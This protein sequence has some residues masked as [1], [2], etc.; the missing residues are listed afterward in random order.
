MSQF[1]L[2]PTTLFGWLFLRF[3]VTLTIQDKIFIEQTIGCNLNITNMMQQGWYTVYLNETQ[4][5]TA[6]K[7]KQIQIYEIPSFKSETRESLEY[8]DYM[9]EVSPDWRMFQTNQSEIYPFY[10][11]HYIISNISSHEIQNDKRILNY[12]KNPRKILNNRYTGGLLQDGV[13]TMTAQNDQ[14]ISHRTLLQHNI[15][16]KGRIITALDTGV[17]LTH[18]FFRDPQQSATSVVDKFNMDHRKIVKLEKVSDIY[19]AAQGHG[20]HVMGT[21]AGESIDPKAGIAAYNGIAPKAKLYV[22]D[23]GNSDSRVDLSGNPDIDKITSNMENIKSRVQSNS[24]TFDNSALDATDTYDT[25]TF[26]S[27]EIL[28]VFANGNTPGRNHILAPANCKN[29]LSVA[30][31]AK[32]E[33]SS[34]FKDGGYTIYLTNGDTKLSI[35]QGNNLVHEDAPYVNIP[36]QFCNGDAASCSSESG[37]LLI[38]NKKLSSSS[39]VSYS[40]V[41]LSS[42]DYTTASAWGS[43]SIL[44]D[45]NEKTTRFFQADHSSQGASTIGTLKPD[46]IAPGSN[47]WSSA[48]S[49]TQNLNYIGECAVSKLFSNSGSSMATPAISGALALIEQYFAEG[50]YPLLNPDSIT[51]FNYI[52]QSLL[53]A[54]L[55]NSCKPIDS[56]PV[57]NYI[58]GFG[59]PS[60]AEGLG[61]GSSGVRFISNSKIN[62]GEHL[63]YI[64]KTTKVHDLSI[65]LCYVDY[66][67]GTKAGY[68]LCADLDLIVKDPNGKIYH[69]NGVPGEFTST[70]EKVTISDATIGTYEISVIFNKDET[71]EH[72]MTYV[73]FSV[74]IMGGFDQDDTNSNNPS[75]PLASERSCVRSCGDGECQGDGTCKCPPEKTG[76]YCQLEYEEIK[77]NKK[78]SKVLNPR[79]KFYF[80]FEN[81]HFGSVDISEYPSLSMPQTSC[82]V[83]VCFGDSGS[84]A[85]ASSM[86]CIT[87]PPTGNNA[88]AAQNGLKMVYGFMYPIFDT[89][90]SIDA[91]LTTYGKIK[92]SDDTFPFY[93]VVLIVLAV[94][95]LVILSVWYFWKCVLPRWEKKHNEESPSMDAAQND[96][97]PKKSHRRSSTKRRGSKSKEEEDQVDQ[98][99]SPEAAS[100]V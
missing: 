11:N 95:I 63:T 98:Q 69:G 16:G 48:A 52:S 21:I 27:Q 99:P 90:C 36:L 14:I 86:G 31:I 79:E 64:I 30:W 22:V 62:N 65:T 97:E 12:I 23:M 70:I 5:L 89:S 81:A 35:V 80:R 50:Y 83:R 71:H 87:K 57:P 84:T 38:C 13:I 44:L 66:P 73:N 46:L 26:N 76:A 78:F 94:I 37:K 61:F 72:D 54:T 15:D 2:S 77:F 55:I 85:F 20:T 43:G 24:W 6:K 39:S 58:E 68:I 51:K 32:L 25:I 42:N 40:Y 60:I 75:V 82:A 33:E 17:D 1:S 96:D 67:G 10:R 4:L 7:I 9:I 100:E 91:T 93:A 28:P 29:L 56:K 49:G 3:L 88:T 8:G 59:M 53:R 74:A 34:D 18:C 47:I 41:V 45:P 92:R 19:D